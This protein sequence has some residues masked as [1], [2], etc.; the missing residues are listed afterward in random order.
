[1]QTIIAVAGVA[2]ALAGLCWNVPAGATE[3][4]LAADQWCP[5]NCGPDE[6]LPGYMIAIARRSLGRAGHTVRYVIVPWARAIAETRAGRYDGIVGT[7][8]EET[9]D[10]VFPEQA[11]G[12]AAHTFYVRRGSS[13]RYTGP[14]SLAQIALGVIRNYSYGGLYETYIRLHPDNPKRVQTAFGAMALVSNIRKL[15]SGRIDA[16]IEDRTVFRHTLHVKMIPDAFSE[17]GVAYM[18]RVYIAFSPRNANAKAYADLLTQALAEM[19]SSGELAEILAVYGVD[20]WEA[21]EIQL[22]APTV[23]PD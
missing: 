20:D 8:R 9:P 5:Y 19:R 18:E 16:L 14:D 13:W 23:E 6:D 12:V 3:I 10:F 4:V 7:G 11:L 2:I 22:D 17:A 1:M 15:R 21:R